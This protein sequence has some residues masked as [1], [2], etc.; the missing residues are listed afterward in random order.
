MHRARRAASLHPS[1]PQNWHSRPR[2]R[3]GSAQLTSVSA[4]ELLSGCSAG[5]FSAPT[6]G[7]GAS[8]GPGLHSNSE[9]GA[10]PHR[11]QCAASSSP[12]RLPAATR[13]TAGLDVLLDALRSQ[14]EA[15]L[16]GDQGRTGLRGTGVQGSEPEGPSGGISATVEEDSLGWRSLSGENKRQGHVLKT[17]GLQDRPEL[18]PRALTLKVTVLSP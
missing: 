17:S 11:A 1:P 6:P 9:L 4:D 16:R 8:P 14:E 2:A 7:H 12:A 13:G 5:P 10:R 3:A 15:S 18:E